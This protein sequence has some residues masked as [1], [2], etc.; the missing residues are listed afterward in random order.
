MTP[1]DDSPSPPARAYTPLAGKIALEE[2]FTLP[3][4]PQ[5][6]SVHAWQ[7]TERYEPV[8]RNLPDIYGR[9]EKMDRYG[10]AL[11]VLSLSSP[12]LQGVPDARLGRE[13]MQR[14]NDELAGIIAKRPD[15][16]AGFAALAMHD[17]DFAAD[18]LERCVHDLGFKGA[19]LNGCQNVGDSTTVAY[20]DEPQYLPFWR[21]VEALG[22][23]VYIHPRD[24]I[25]GQQR[26]IDG[27]PELHASVW[28]YTP[29]TAGHA[30][31]LITSG[32]FDKCPRLQVILGHLGEAL[33][34][35]IDRID[36]RVTYIEEMM[37]PRLEHP[38][39]YY[40]RNNFYFT[41]AGAF[42]TLALQNAIGVLGVERILFSID[43]PFETF[44]DAVDWFETAPF[45]P[46]DRRR[47]GYENAS[48]L[49]RLRNPGKNPCNSSG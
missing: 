16:F 25:D 48:R 6:G 44:A 4:M 34:F 46:E 33:S 5:L 36:R 49:L 10:V 20:L 3:N 38:P 2:A 41:T 40:L 27:R 7:R 17:P 37:D 30:M 28:A 19:L 47:I 22:L 1:T 42:D 13:Y 43:D 9:I 26:I 32:L 23:P 45:S 31:R 18:E 8:L 14:A 24:F 35:F 21:R 11:E 39:S 29:E 12:G 15:R